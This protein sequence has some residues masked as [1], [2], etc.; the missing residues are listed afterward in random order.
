M[1]NRFITNN[2]TE[3]LSKIK[4]SLQKCKSFSFSVS[5][6]KHAGLLLLE[7]EIEEALDR[8]V[9]GKLITST[10]QNFTDIPALN[11]FMEWS[12]K[13]SNFQC[14]LDF[15]CFGENGFHSKGYIFEHENSYEI[16]VGSTNITRY[17]L[18]KNVEWNIS[19]L[20]KEKSDSY[21]SANDEFNNLWN[22]TLKLD[23]ELIKKYKIQLD[24]AIDRWDM[25]FFDPEQS[26]IKPNA[27]QR[28]ALKEIRRYRDLGEKR[29][30]VVSATGS[31]KTYLAAFDARNFDAKRLL[32][33]VHR[34]TI[35][36]EARSTFEK[37]FG[38]R[39][40]YG[41][42]TGNK[43]ELDCDFIFASNTM[44]SRHLDEFDKKEF[45]YIILDEA[46]HSSASTYKKIIE[47]FEPEFIL[48]LTAT[49]ERMDNEDVFELFDKNVPYELRLN[50]AIN[51]D[52]VVPF[53]YYGIRDSFVDYSIEDKY[54]IAKEISKTENIDFI[55]S[56]IQKHLPDGKL[57]A[58]AFCS[59]ISHAELMAEEFNNIGYCALSL[60]GTNDFGQRQKAFAD[61][62]DD[63]VDLQIICTVDILN[64]G[65]DIPSVNMILFLRPTES[66]TIF[67]QQL[68]RGLR[69][70]PNKDYVTVLDF[71][72]NNYG[73]SVQIA[74]ALGTLGKNT[75]LD[76]KTLM[77]LVDTSFKDIGVSGVQIHIDT[78]SKE[79]MI[80]HISDVNFNRKDFLKKDYLNFK[81]Y[82]NSNSYPSHMDYLNCEYAPNIL[83]FMKSKIGGKKNFS[84]YNFLHK[85]GE[86][87]LPLFDDDQ[88][89]IINEL[90]E[91]LPVVRVDEYLIVKQLNETNE[92]KIDD[93]IGFNDKVTLDTLNHALSI[94]EKTKIIL[95][96]KKLNLKN[97][98]IDF[99]LYIKDLIQYGLERYAIEFGNYKGK[100]K[101]YANYSKR[102]VSQILNVDYNMS[103]KQ[104][105]IIYPDSAGISYFFVSIEK[106]KLK[107]EKNNYKNK[108]ISPNI[109]QWESENRTQIDNKNGI[110]LLKTKKTHIFIRKTEEED[111][112]VSPFTYFGMGVLTN[113]RKS[114]VNVLKEDGTREDVDTLLFDIKLDNEVPEEYHFEFEIPEEK[115]A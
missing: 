20:S 6:I 111:G 57:K 62:Q 21:I 19:I 46:H 71:I 80:R 12:K 36:S 67:L 14:H 107:E 81:K 50:D 49:P 72:G 114:K 17:A 94:L 4:E 89:N 48:G 43:Q 98:N 99:E 27:M 11:K 60:T 85:I 52:L 32:F 29:A 108:F 88:I 18:L 1:D 76:K 74:T 37:V 97:T 77:Y 103:F 45:D 47:Y 75:S 96:N 83:R 69:K 91:L 26:Y 40:T 86:E 24:Y 55:H 87:N 115:K 66:S 51:N 39:K 42:Y 3:F 79:E 13:Y 64:E 31:G 23:D 38:A 101:L 100:F 41:L 90:S 104:R 84:Y 10:Y 93:L 22:K 53:H 35:L 44:I 58:I 33:V 92:I 5:F 7:R 56:E 34:D 82:L 70:Y 109:L 28:K 105:G 78:L 106:D 59:N 25:D 30:L 15:G 9:E 112:I 8:G 102:Q 2:N 113:M 16:I 68:G 61:L 63:N 110:K 95:E 65:V 54:K 73:R